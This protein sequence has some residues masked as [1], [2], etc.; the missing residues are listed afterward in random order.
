MRGETL[1]AL[2]EQASC[3][4]SS[5]DSMADTEGCGGQT[6]GAFFQQIQRFKF[7]LVVDG[8]EKNGPGDF[9][10]E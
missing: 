8:D 7:C 9:R 6:S 1:W 10:K 2:Q 3:L 4:S 5:E